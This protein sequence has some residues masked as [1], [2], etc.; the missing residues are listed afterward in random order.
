MRGGRREGHGAWHT[1]RSIPACAGEPRESRWNGCQSWDHP[2]IRR[3][4][5]VF[6]RGLDSRTGNIPANRGNQRWI[7]SSCSVWGAS[8]LRGGICIITWWGT[9][10]GGASP[11]SGEPTNGQTYRAEP[12]EHP[13]MRGGTC[14]SRTTSAALMGASPYTRGNLYRVTS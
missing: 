3:G 9:K 14:I 6:D 5:P 1:E 8:P 13:R 10:K 4:N 12:T 7:F 2:R 11:H